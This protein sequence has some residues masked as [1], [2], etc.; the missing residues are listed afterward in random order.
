MGYTPEEE[1]I[2][3][4]IEKILEGIKEFQDASDKRLDNDEYKDI[5]KHD[6][7]NMKK[8]LIDV[9]YDLRKFI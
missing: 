7:K 5:H 9:A 8:D 1:N 4:P 2:Q 3:D 6:L